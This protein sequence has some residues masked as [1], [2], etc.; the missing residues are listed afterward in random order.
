[1]SHFWR[2]FGYVICSILLAISLILLPFTYGISLIGVV[3]FAVLIWAIKKSGQVES[4]KEDLKYIADRERRLDKE[5]AETE[6]K[7][8]EKQQKLE[9]TERIEEKQK[10]LEDLKKKTETETD[11]EANGK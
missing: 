7:L 4:M 9:G 6:R 10:R 1:M 11:N 3:G 2:V 8:A 5:L